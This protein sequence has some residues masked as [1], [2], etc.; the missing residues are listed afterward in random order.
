[1]AKGEMETGPLRVWDRE[2]TRPWKSSPKLVRRK[3]FS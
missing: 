1:M 3:N 2:E